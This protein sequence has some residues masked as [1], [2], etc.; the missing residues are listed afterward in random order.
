MMKYDFAGREWNVEDFGTPETGAP[1]ILLLAG[2]GE[3]TDRMRAALEEAGAPALWLA[4]PVNIDWDRD[5]TPW[6]TSGSGGRVFAGGAGRLL[7]SVR[8]LREELEA[9]LRPGAMFP[10]GY[11]LGGLA[12]LWL[13]ANTPFDGAGSCSGSLWYPGW[14]DFLEGHPL[15]GLVYLS[16]GGKEK[17]TRDPQMA[18]NPRCTDFTRQLCQRTARRTALISEPGCHFRDPEGRLARAIAWLCG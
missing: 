10:V 13:H 18:R 2:D 11:S 15:T 4:F 7:E 6:P 5:Y 12:A 1:L 3:L 14:T 16:L 8:A 9:E 17:N